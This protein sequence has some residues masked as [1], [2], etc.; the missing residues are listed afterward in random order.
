ML[1]GP[2]FGFRLA[3]AYVDI[4]GIEFQITDDEVEVKQK[5]KR[6]LIL[7]RKKTK[8]MTADNFLKMLTEKLYVSSSKHRADLLTGKRF[9]AV[10]EIFPPTKTKNKKK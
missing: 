1:F 3:G 5:G 6:K 7:Q 2:S 10:A 4:S 8:K 9:D